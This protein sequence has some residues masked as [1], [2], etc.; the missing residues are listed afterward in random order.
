MP[1]PHPMPLAWQARPLSERRGLP[2]GQAGVTIE[3]TF[4]NLPKASL[5]KKIST[6]CE[7]ATNN[8]CGSMTLRNPAYFALKKGTH[9]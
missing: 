2:T 8:I 6:L 4:G 5:R 1:R 9:K 3:I 7:L